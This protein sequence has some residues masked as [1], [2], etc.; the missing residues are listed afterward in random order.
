MR[1]LTHSAMRSR[2]SWIKKHPALPTED[3]VFNTHARTRTEI[4]SRENQVNRVP[5]SHMTYLISLSRSE[6]PTERD[7]CISQRLKL[8]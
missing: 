4:P 6:K 7:A 5:K 8:S 2:C 3:F 1:C